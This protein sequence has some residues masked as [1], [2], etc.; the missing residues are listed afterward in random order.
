MNAYREIDETLNMS[1]LGIVE[2]KGRYGTHMHVSESTK[3][4]IH[5]TMYKAVLDLPPDLHFDVDP[6][7]IESLEMWSKDEIVQNI[8]MDAGITPHTLECFL[9]VVE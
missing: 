1:C 5:F 9:K 7:S 3:L 2:L 8:Y 6:R 4:R